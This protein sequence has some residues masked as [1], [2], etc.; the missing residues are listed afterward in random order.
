[1]IRPNDGHEVIPQENHA[2]KLITLRRQTFGQARVKGSI[3]QPVLNILRIGNVEL[4]P[5]SNLISPALAISP[6][7]EYKFLSAITLDG[8][9][10]LLAGITGCSSP[11]SRLA[12]KR[13]QRQ[14]IPRLE[15]DD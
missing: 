8:P 1:M 3:D 14:Q 4:K 12:A 15:E 11:N 2:F 10:C 7:Y 6:M 9:G 13:V 5:S